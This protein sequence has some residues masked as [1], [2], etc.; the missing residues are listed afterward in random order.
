M[1]AITERIAACNKDQ[2]QIQAPLY[3]RRILRP[4]M[5]RTLTILAGSFQLSKNK[6]RAHKPLGVVNRNSAV[7][8]RTR[9][10]AQ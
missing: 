7:H 5:P 8:A 1:A 3:S 2:G 6:D 4:A 10:I 9:V